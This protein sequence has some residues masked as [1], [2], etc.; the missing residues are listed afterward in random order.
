MLLLVSVIALPV[1]IYSTAYMKDDE[2]YK[3]YFTWLSFF[4]FSMLALV[5]ADNLVLFYGFWELVGFSSYLLI[6]FW[7][8]KEK[9]IQANKKAFIMNRIGDVGL[10][11]A[12]LILFAQYHTFDIVQL[13]GD[14]G[15]SIQPIDDKIWFLDRADKRFTCY[16]AIHSLR[17]HI[18]R[19]SGKIGTVPAAYL[20]A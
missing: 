4:C 3:R 2:R 15:I 16:M 10:L 6:G 5:V 8:T 12:I 1:H 11:I 18:F 13:F 7:F 19:R 20:A 9:A 17:G 14:G